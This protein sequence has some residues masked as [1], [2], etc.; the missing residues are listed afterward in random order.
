MRT[1]LLAAAAVAALGS[2]SA[3]AGEGNGPNFP[4]LQAVSAGLTT[5]FATPNQ[6][7]VV[8]TD[9]LS[10]SN[11]G[12][13]TSGIPHRSLGHSNAQRM[14]STLSGFTAG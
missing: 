12:Q 1:L 11:P 4:G 6:P 5:S 8:T 3:Y 7:P 2:A 10:S 13:V 9:L 14:I